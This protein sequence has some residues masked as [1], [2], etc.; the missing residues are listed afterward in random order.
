[1]KGRGGPGMSKYWT[2]TCLIPPKLSPPAF[3]PRFLGPSWES[4]GG[5]KSSPLYIMYLLPEKLSE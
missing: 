4:L 1:M 3:A 2:L 5:I